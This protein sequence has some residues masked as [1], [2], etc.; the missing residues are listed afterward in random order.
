MHI[1]G[2]EG[3]ER[4]EEFGFFKGGVEKVVRI[5]SC[6]QRVQSASHQSVLGD[7]RCASAL[8]SA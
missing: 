5:W 3:E 1:D 6:R 8:E 2:D 4:K 7:S